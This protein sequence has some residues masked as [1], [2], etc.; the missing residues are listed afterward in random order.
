VRICS[1]IRLEIGTKRNWLGD[2]CDWIKAWNWS[3][4]SYKDTSNTDTS[5]IQ[6]PLQ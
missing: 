6:T 4:L 3:H 2:H 5:L 1:I